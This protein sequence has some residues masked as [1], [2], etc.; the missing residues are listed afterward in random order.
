MMK[1]EKL[2]LSSLMAGLLIGIA[3]GMYLT[4][5]KYIG[6]FLFAFALF[7]ICAN[8]YYLYTGKIGFVSFKRGEWRDYL[9]MLFGNVLGAGIGAVLCGMANPAL[10]LVASDLITSKMTVSWFSVLIKGA[11]CG[12]CMYFAVK[13]N[14]AGQKN[15]FL[16]FAPVFLMI[17]VFLLTGFEHSIADAGYMFLASRFDFLWKLILVVIGNSIGA[18]GVRLLDVKIARCECD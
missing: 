7:L 2:L 14:A 16:R 15:T 6:A 8:G 5:N 3:D 9:L 1:Y 12:V 10:R 18:I 13:A 11:L 4:T 17:A